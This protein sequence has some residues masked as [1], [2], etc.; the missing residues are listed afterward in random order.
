MNS[1]TVM[2]Q[3]GMHEIK[4]TQSTALPIKLFLRKSGMTDPST[5]LMRQAR[6]NAIN[7]IP[8]TE[9]PIAVQSVQNLF[10]DFIA[11]SSKVQLA[12]GGSRVTSELPGC[13]AGP[14]FDAMSGSVLLINPSA[15]PIVKICSPASVF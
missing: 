15:N 10:V 11:C 8:A 2:V 13:S 6:V 5:G 12:E 1:A 7:T 14:L 3:I 9:N 4:R